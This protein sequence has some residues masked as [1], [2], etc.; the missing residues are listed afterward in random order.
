MFL[1]DTHIL[2]WYL[3]NSNQITDTIY[4]II[5]NQK[6]IYV[7]IVS[8]LEIAL[9]KNIGKLQLNYSIQ[10][11]ENLCIE[12]NISILPIKSIYLDELA[13]LPKIHNDPLI[14]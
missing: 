9:K 4:E 13:N 6:T 11:I 10:D 8:F 12:K 7:S 2:L 5:N 3:S 14:G 1:L